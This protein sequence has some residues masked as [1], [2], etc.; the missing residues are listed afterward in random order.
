MTRKRKF[1]DSKIVE[2]VLKE[3]Y[4]LGT[5]EVGFY[6]TGEPLINKNLDKYI[7]G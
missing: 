2:K 1:I 3:C 7:F 6:A 4:D 5:R